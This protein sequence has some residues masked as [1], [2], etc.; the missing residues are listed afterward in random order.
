MLLQGTSIWFWPS[1]SL[2]TLAHCRSQERQAL[3]LP[4]DAHLLQVV[5]TLDD[6]A[7]PVN[8]SFQT[9]LSGSVSTVRIPPQFCLLAIYTQTHTSSCVALVLASIGIPGNVVVFPLPFAVANKRYVNSPARM[10]RQCSA[11]GATVVWLVADRDRARPHSWDVLPMGPARLLQWTNRASA[12]GYLLMQQPV[13]GQ[14]TTSLATLPIAAGRCPRKGTHL[15]CRP[16]RRKSIEY[17][18]ALLSPGSGETSQAH[19][20]EALLKLTL[21]RLSLCLADPCPASLAAVGGLQKAP[22]MRRYIYTPSTNGLARAE[23]YLVSTSYNCKTSYLTKVLCWA[24]CLNSRLKPHQ[25]VA[26]H[27]RTG[28]RCPVCSDVRGPQQRRRA[29]HMS[30]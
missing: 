18:A 20:F 17:G 19:P 7:A 29:R 9:G 4:R 30:S 6:I 1:G 5:Q 28:T 16:E 10:A 23:Q 3:I 8:C 24:P 22:C 11:G 26:L 27:I 13:P 14:V 2:C 15:N 21:H 25:C 12:A